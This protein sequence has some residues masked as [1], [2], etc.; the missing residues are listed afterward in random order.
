MRVYDSKGPL[1]Y[2]VGGKGEDSKATFVQYRCSTLMPFTNCFAP[3][4]YLCPVVV[5]DERNHEA[6]AVLGMVTLRVHEVLKASARH[7]GWYTLTSG[8]GY[9]RVKVSLVFT[10]LAVSIPPPL[11]GWGIGTVEII[12]TRV[13]VRDDAPT[14]Q[15]KF[16][17]KI[18]TFGGTESL[19]P[20]DRDR[21]N[22]APLEAFP[23]GEA[24]SNMA[25][26]GLKL[27]QFSWPL[28]GEPEGGVRLPLRQRYPGVVS[29]ALVGERKGLSRRPRYGYSLVRLNQLPDGGIV[30][31]HL[32][33]LEGQECEAMNQTLL[34][35]ESHPD[36][37]LSPNERVEAMMAAAD[38]ARHKKGPPSDPNV[39][40]GRGS[41]LVVGLAQAS[42]VA[43][44]PS[45]SKNAPGA[46]VQHY[47]R[48]L[49][50][51]A[52]PPNKAMSQLSM[53]VSAQQGFAAHKAALDPTA[54]AATAAAAAAGQEPVV[55]ISSGETRSLA[56]TQ[57]D[58]HH[59]NY[60]HH[61]H[62][63]HGSTASTSSIPERKVGDQVGVLE[64]TLVL[65]PGVSTEH[66]GL[67]MHDDEMRIAYETFLTATDAQE[68]APPGRY[69]PGQMKSQGERSASEGRA[70]TAPESGKG[71]KQNQHPPPLPPKDNREEPVA[72]HDAA[73]SYPAQRE[74]SYSHAD[75][76]N[77]L[78]GYLPHS[79]S[80]EYEDKDDAD[81]LYDDQ[82][83]DQTGDET[84]DDDLIDGSVGPDVQERSRD[85]SRRAVMHRQQ[86]GAAQLK[87]FRTA[88]WLS[89][90]IA[91]KAHHV[92]YAATRDRQF[93]STGVGHK[94]E[95]EG[96]SHF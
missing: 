29:F 4:C 44:A 42:S 84:D 49:E 28:E 70:G 12:R 32:P 17:V 61:P 66:R 59:H 50:T 45:A 3:I 11:A 69:V 95:H 55:S 1:C 31:L 39:G 40:N 43:Y 54:T 41:G 36:E 82:T 80:T 92:R 85:L 83:D 22:L 16:G 72:D 94:L 73:L 65:W 53:T 10:P 63:Q 8:M 51:F 77:G 60:H 68:R 71:G 27:S 74:A 2:I 24:G 34:R 38:L 93:N 89:R 52:H 18:S 88:R 96:V 21:S 35:M 14:A 56:S 67:A 15:R 57:P 6:D 33:I 7:T 19:T 48:L 81:L 76:S 47:P 91:E 9:G 75:P 23:S 30:T 37:L 13:L 87:A 25:D 86:R 79:R 64:V 46:R 78:P 90:G 26:P 5:K 20:R 62:H 58:P